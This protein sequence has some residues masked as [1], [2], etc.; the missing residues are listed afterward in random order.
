M[1]LSATATLNMDLL[2]SETCGP[3]IPE[4]DKSSEGAY[5]NSSASSSTFRKQECK[6]FV[7]VYVF[8]CHPS[9]QKLIKFLIGNCVA[10][11][12]HFP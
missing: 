5:V 11:A 7:C 2:N 8:D 10:T 4:E 12:E 1:K 9:M 3:P 6:V